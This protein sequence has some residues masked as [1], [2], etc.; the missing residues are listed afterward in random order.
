M[1]SLDH[2]VNDN[3]KRSWNQFS[4]SQIVFGVYLLTGLGLWTYVSVVNFYDSI[5]LQCVQCDA[6]RPLMSFV[7]KNLIHWK[8]YKEFIS[9]QTLGLNMFK[10]SR[11][12]A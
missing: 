3:I 8:D 7:P 5:T 6:H 4:C 10:V 1:H 12:H 11:V 2:D 9:T